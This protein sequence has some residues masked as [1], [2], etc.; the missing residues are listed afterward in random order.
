MHTDGD[1]W[2]ATVNQ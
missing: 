2:F 1:V